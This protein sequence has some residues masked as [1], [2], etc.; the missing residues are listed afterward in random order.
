[1]APARRNHGERRHVVVNEPPEGFRAAIAEYAVDQFGPLSPDQLDYVLSRAEPR[2]A[3]LG[4]T[5]E[6]IRHYRPA[7]SLLAEF[8]IYVQHARKGIA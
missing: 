8:A 1:M 5:W 3:N 7:N 2:Y 4:M 6:E